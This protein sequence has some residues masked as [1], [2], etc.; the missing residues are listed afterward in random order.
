MAGTGGKDGRDTALDETVAPED[1]AL[2]AT[3][4]PE[5]VGLDATVV[6]AD[7]IVEAA[8]TDTALD[9]TVAAPDDTALDATVADT[10]EVALDATVAADGSEATM[11]GQAGVSTTS[12]RQTRVRGPKSSDRATLAR[13]DE[14]GRYV[15][16]SM[17]GAGGMGEVYTA[18]DPELDRKVAIKV[19]RE[20]KG[21]V[22]ETTARARL[23][24]EAQSLAR[25]SHP[26][27][28]TVYDVGTVDSGDVYIAMEFIE[29]VTLTDWLQRAERSWQEIAQTMV[30]AGR[31]LAAA[32]EAGLTHRDFKPDNVLIGADGRVRVI[33]FGVALVSEDAPPVVEDMARR[34]LSPTTTGGL[35]GTPAYMAPEQFTGG[36][37]SS[38]TDQFAFGIALYQALTGQL[39]FEGKT[40]LTLAERVKEGEVRDFPR[41]SDA[42]RWLQ[43]LVL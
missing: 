38:S 9:A 40:L 26:N 35:V 33:D 32:H 21:G 29:G 7:T 17:L 14:L 30:E 27:V 41:D 36:D 20:R 34:E 16:L 37:I 23:L 2:D 8:T 13:G 12:A 19:I 43:T 24:A 18:Y 25:L 1:V 28:V 42:P 11:D 39:P 3:V 6:P 4:A 15:V 5:D 22:L 31:G 10:G